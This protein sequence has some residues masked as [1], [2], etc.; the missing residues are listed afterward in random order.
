MVNAGG[1]EGWRRLILV[2][3]AYTTS[4][5]V[6]VSL[7]LSAIASACSLSVNRIRYNLGKL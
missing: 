4:R 7:Q 1:F 5:L 3:L 6:L 2:M